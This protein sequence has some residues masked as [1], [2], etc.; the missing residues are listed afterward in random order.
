M[1][2]RKV[3]WGWL[4]GSAEVDNV[5]FLFDFNPY[6]YPYG[7]MLRFTKDLPY[8]RRDIAIQSIGIY[9]TRS[10][11]KGRINYW[12]KLIFEKLKEN[13]GDGGGQ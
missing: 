12:T 5:S 3:S 2:L 11:D 8:R 4:Y 9:K 1:K 10:S 6:S 7:M 13:K